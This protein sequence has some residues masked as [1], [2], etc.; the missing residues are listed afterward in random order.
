[1]MRSE[2]VGIVGAG[3]FGTALAHVV[4]Q[5]GRPV[6]IWSQ[7]E[8]VVAEI[9]DKH[10]NHDRLPGV[11]LH[12]G[13]EATSSAAELA[14]RSGFIVLAVGTDDVRDRARQLG[15]HLDG[16]HIVVHAIGGLA[17]PL[18][19]PVSVVLDEELPTLR[20]GA[21]AGPTR[22]EDL[23]EG[24]VSSAVCA[25][26]FDDV[27]AR[28]RELLSSPPVLR[29]YCSRDLLGVELASA[30]A[31]VY[32]VAL[33]L[34]DGLKVGA[35]TRAV[36]TT[37]SVAEAARLGTAV[38]ADGWT[39]AGLAGLGNLLVRGYDQESS[40][41]EYRFGQ[42]LAAGNSDRG[43]L[44]VGARA[45]HALARMA[46][47]CGLRMPI[48]EAVDGILRGTASL[49]EAAASLADTVAPLE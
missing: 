11:E 25:S 22:V 1:M 27:T 42:G 39:F 41:P 43:S 17:E 23:A 40:V 19:V 3:P 2:Q 20:I 6:L 35:G 7:T 36:L 5:A 30:L 45:A 34:A 21:L 29:L 16:S 26:A 12:P 37:R 8:P 15:D 49:K 24:R 33:G 4:A 48:L 18:D 44:P 14:E 10:Q 38:G 31:G 9:N 28:A 32:T 46:T 47:S 13:V